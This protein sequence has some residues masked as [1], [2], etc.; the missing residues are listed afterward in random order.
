M[1]QPTP[2]HACFA[3]LVGFYQADD[4]SYPLLDADLAL[5]SSGLYVQGVHPLVT[6]ENIVNV[7]PEFKS[8][9]YP[10]WDTANAYKKDARIY[11]GAA[12]Y[13]AIADVAS[14]GAEPSTVPL[15]WK[16]IDPFSEWLRRL[17]KESCSNLAN[18]VVRQKTLSQAGKSLLES[19][20]LYQG[21]GAL[22]DRIIK[23]S[24]FVGFQI[25]VASAEGLVTT[26][27]QVAIQTDAAQALTFYLY[28]SSQADPVKT[29]VVNIA[30]ANVFQWADITDAIVGYM[31][32]KS[33][34]G[35]VW[36][37]GYYEDDLTGQA[38][39]KTIDLSRAPCLSCDSWNINAYN[40][41]SQY[42][43]IQ[44]F[45]VPESYVMQ[46][47]SLWDMGG[48]RYAYDTNWG[49][50]LSLQV[51]CDV[52]TVMC[53]NRLVLANA[54]RMQIALDLLQII[55]FN[56]RINA[57]SD[58]TKKFARAEL[59]TKPGATTFMNIYLDQL[60]KANLDLS[61]LNGAC[62]PKST[63]GT[64]RYGAV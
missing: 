23:H 46:D 64:I 19:Q 38:V 10:N 40:R 7:A 48:V 5:A 34:A 12:V 63:N 58:T 31:A 59:S 25:S 8:F 20:Q 33:D 28:N 14:G 27:S 37:F 43:S 2:L 24:R 3:G 15:I 55:G 45:Y 36:Y 17:Y 60:E 44:A 30:K 11:S 50:N 56:T 61:G 32:N 16:L 53:R 54:L 13:A 6:V 9:S 42:S 47:K 22:T 62:F 18:T 35:S 52:T 26:I 49:L 1:F 21:G 39:N 57:I 4:P 41:W 29:F 51:T